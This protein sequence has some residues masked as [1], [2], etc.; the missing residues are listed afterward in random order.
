MNHF[1]TETL[2]LRLLD[3]RIFIPEISGLQVFCRITDLWWEKISGELF[4]EPQH[5]KYIYISSP[6][7]CLQLLTCN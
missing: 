5:K 6:L 7:F 2:D 1:H 3:M 4:D